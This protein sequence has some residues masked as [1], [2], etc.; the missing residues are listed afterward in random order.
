MA[1][2][3]IGEEDG[4]R[5]SLSPWQPWTECSVEC[6]FYGVQTTHRFCDGAKLCDDGYGRKKI[7]VCELRGTMVE[8]VSSGFVVVVVGGQEPWLE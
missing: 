3:R 6:G 5:G 7:Q 8:K 1:R 2:G 4:N